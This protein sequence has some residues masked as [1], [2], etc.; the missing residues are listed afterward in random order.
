M[1][2]DTLNRM[3]RYAYALCHQQEQAYDLVQ[4]VVTKLL[5]KGTDLSAT[6][7]PYLLTSIRNLHIDQYRRDQRHPHV[8]LVESISDQSRYFD[9]VCTRME[10]ETLLETMSSEERELIYLN[11][12]EGYSAQEI[13]D[14]REAPRGTI[15]ARIH[16]LKAKVK[17]KLAHKTEGIK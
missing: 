4:S 17:Q 10:A 6:P 7:L 9:D 11:S 16:R 14:M 1:D 12:V 13:A 3:Y 2:R 8:E 15:L 5:A